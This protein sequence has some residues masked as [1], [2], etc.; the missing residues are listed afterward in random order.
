[1]NI[2]ECKKRLD[3]LAK[4]RE[5]IY[6]E[7]LQRIDAETDRLQEHI[8][9]ICKHH[10]DFLLVRSETPEDEYGKSLNNSETYEITC[11]ICNKYRSVYTRYIH[12]NPDITFQDLFEMTQD[13]C[14]KL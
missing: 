5:E 10:N 13:E 6:K 9:S 8:K 14:R 1:M 7:K 4:E 11:T 3:E 2:A 12:N